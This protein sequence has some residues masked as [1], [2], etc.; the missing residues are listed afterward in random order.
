M[1]LKINVCDDLVEQIALEIMEVL[2]IGNY[3]S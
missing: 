3:V 1:N 2:F